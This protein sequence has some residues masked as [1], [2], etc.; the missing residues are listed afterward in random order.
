MVSDPKDDDHHFAGPK[1]GAPF[2]SD[3]IH[4]LNLDSE[5]SGFCWQFFAQYVVNNSP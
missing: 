5:F 1:K 3:E 4:I 2:F